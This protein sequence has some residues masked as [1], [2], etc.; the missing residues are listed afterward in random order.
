MHI[1]EKMA[2]TVLNQLKD[3]PMNLILVVRAKNVWD[4]KKMEKCK[5][6]DFILRCF[7]HSRVF[8][9]YSDSIRKTGE[10]TKS[11]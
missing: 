9:G 11:N 10:E 4:T 3:I 2:R 8:D 7:G 6:V 1:V 5:P